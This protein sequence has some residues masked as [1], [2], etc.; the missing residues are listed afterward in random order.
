M[1]NDIWTSVATLRCQTKTFL[2]P[3]VLVAETV[4][5]ATHLQMKVSSGKWIVL[6][7]CWPCGADGIPGLPLAAN[8]LLVADC[9]AGALIGKI[10]GSSAS[11]SDSKPFAIGR[12]CVIA[13]P[14]HAVGPL[15]VGINGAWRPVEITEDFLLEVCGA[16][17]TS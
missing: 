8:Q 13:V 2:E 1:L 15:F 5:G 7:D 16:T 3:W 9:P 14:E 6:P 4:L 10:G 17:P 11:T 12:H